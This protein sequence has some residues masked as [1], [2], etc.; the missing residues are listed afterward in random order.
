VRVAPRSDVAFLV[1]S[2]GTTGLP[3]GV[4]LSHYNV[5]ANLL[6]MAAVE[7]LHLHPFGGPAGAGDKV[8]GVVPFYH[9]YVSTTLF[10]DRGGREDKRWGGP[11]DGVV[12]RA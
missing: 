4:R 9:V 7:G 6:Q 5:V 3:K 11:A 1:Y 2:S 10:D 8:L 12:L